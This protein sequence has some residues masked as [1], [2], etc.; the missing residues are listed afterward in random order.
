MSGTCTRS[1][2]FEFRNRPASWWVINNPV[3]LPGEPGVESDTGQLK[4]GN[5]VSTWSA[6]PYVGTGTGGG[7]G[8]TGPTGPTGP[9]APAIGFDG[10]NAMS[11]YSVVGPKLD[12]GTA[13]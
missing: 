7:G 12:C 10:G 9:V 5:G 1:V 4:I 8:S 2:R 3:L 6:L 13:Q 11:D